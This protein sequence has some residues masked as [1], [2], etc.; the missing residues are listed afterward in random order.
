LIIRVVKNAAAQLMGHTKW[1]LSK[2]NHNVMLPAMRS[3]A[4]TLITDM[5]LQFAG[6]RRYTGAMEAGFGQHDA[7]QDSVAITQ[8]APHELF[9]REGT[10]GPYKGFPA[11]VLD[12]ARHHGY[13]RRMQ[14]KIAKSIQ[15]TGTS[16]NFVP[17][18]PS[19]E[20]R[21]EYPEWVLNEHAKDMKAWGK[22]IGQGA[23]SYITT[24]DTWRAR[25]I[26]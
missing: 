13:S 1:T 22:Q 23:V 6:A 12:W 16:K 7:S 18:H 4:D 19:G 5:K 26:G 24:G 3:I 11:P 14:F 8:A 2:M 10:V 25:R 9:I 17:Y 20:P 15:K 21:F